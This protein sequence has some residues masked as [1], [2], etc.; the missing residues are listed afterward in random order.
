MGTYRFK[1]NWGLPDYDWDSY[2]NWGD[3]IFR[4]YLKLEYRNQYFK[5]RD[6]SKPKIKYR[7][8]KGGYGV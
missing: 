4:H 1:H 6:L 8:R 7:K 3:V 5:N 2:I